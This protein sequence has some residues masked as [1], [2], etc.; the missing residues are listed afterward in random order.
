MTAVAGI[1]VLLIVGSGVLYGTMQLLQIGDFEDYAGPG[2]GQQVIEVKPGDTT[3]AIGATLAEK[4]VVASSAAFVVAAKGNQDVA[5]IQPGFYLMKKKMSG[6]G[7]VRRILSDEASVG[8]VEIRGGMRLED[9][10]GPKGKVTPGILS[11]LAKATCVGERNPKKC[12]TSEEMHAAAKGADLASLGV[13]K[14]AVDPASHAPAPKRRLEGLIMPGIYDVKPSDDPKAVLRSVLTTSAAKMRAAGLP[15]AAESTG[16]EP[17]EIL[18]IAS[19]VQS[20]GIKQDFGKVARVIHNRVEEKMPLQ[21]DSTI[22]YPLDNPTLLTQDAD[23]KRP[24]PYNTYLNDGLT[25]TPISSASV[26]AIEAAVKPD[27]GEWLYFVKCYKD[28][29]SCFSKTIAEHNAARR[30]AEAR[31]AY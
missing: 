9:Q 8:R 27:E 3:S 1:F 29:R 30:E 6:A 7:A 13:P 10:T 28:G 31:G 14:W 25:P 21:L 24:G 23:R 11:R 4:D 19:L 15:S 17:Y 5:S 12:V 22:N 18:T 20:E 16:F 2:T 26:P